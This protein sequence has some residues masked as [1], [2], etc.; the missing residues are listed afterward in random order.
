MAAT[1]GKRSALMN[2]S[3]QLVVDVRL[4]TAA[5]RLAMT[6]SFDRDLGI[7]HTRLAARI[8]SGTAS[9]L[10]PGDEQWIVR[11]SHNSMS[12]ASIWHMIGGVSARAGSSAGNR[13]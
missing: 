3:L 13:K 10:S 12:P 11:E 6:L 1:W 7:M 2:R 9:E 5:R 4:A 8:K